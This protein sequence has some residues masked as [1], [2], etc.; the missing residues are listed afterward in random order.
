[1]DYRRLFLAALLSFGFLFAWEKFFPSA[2]PAKTVAAGPEAA[3]AASSSP[4]APAGGATRVEVAT[5]LAPVEPLADTEERKIKIETRDASV[6]LSNRGAEI[7]SYVLKNHQLSK[8]GGLEL[9]RRRVR[10]AYPYG[11]VGARGGNHPLSQKLFVV[12]R[13]EKEGAE[14]I[15]FTFRGPEG[16]VEKDFTFRPDGLFDV[17]VSGRSPRP[18]SLVVGPGLRDLTKDEYESRFERR[19][20]IY[21]AAGAAEDLDPKS[22]AESVEIGATG[23][24]W[25]GLGDQ[26]FFAAAIPR[27]GLEKATYAPVLLTQGEGGVETTPLPKKDDLRPDQKKLPRD[28]LLV[29]TPKAERLEISSYWG[30]KEY[31]RLAAFPFHLEKAVRLGTFGFLALP[32]LKGLQWLHANGIPNYGWAIVL[33]TT[34][35]K[36]VLLPLTH[37]STLSMRKMQGLNPR[38]QA[39]REKWRPKMRDK[40]GRPNLEAQR[41]MN[42][43]VMALY[44]SEGVN[45][46]G[47]CLPLLL[48]M[49]IFFA[50]YQ[51]LSSAVELRNAPWI[52]WIQDL[53]A[54][55]PYFVLPLV[56]GATQVLQMRMTPMGGDPIQRRLFQ[57]MPIFMTVL[58]L[59]FPSGLVLYWLTNNVLTIIQQ[60]AYNKFAPLE[61]AEATSTPSRRKEK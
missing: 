58:F 17:A 45:P 29:L 55:D 9:V 46:A 57:L 52:A 35:L 59:N 54:R 10:G 25:F 53:S 13:S 37:K 4:K 15:R 21:F 38:V 42:E 8:G 41:K 22:T 34:L 2:P 40:Q 26:Y 19:T 30:A 32:L 61:E 50:F 6:V 31:D 33:M 3:A 28:F 48:Q 49:P 47:G 23:A 51:V 60:A 16:V 27:E 56:M 18:W 7:T 36:L 44:K 14:R 11:F 24:G 20:G 1:M 43:E 39:L 12:E 5:P